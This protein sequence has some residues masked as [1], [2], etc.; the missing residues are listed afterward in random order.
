M[1]NVQVFFDKN[2]WFKWDKLK[3][4]KK[5]SGTITL[6]RKY[7]SMLKKKQQKKFY[8]T[9]YFYALKKYKTRSTKYDFLYN[10][11]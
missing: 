11:N 10:L 2:N 8:L 4:S 9:L 6:L 7:L 3:F 1:K 5:T